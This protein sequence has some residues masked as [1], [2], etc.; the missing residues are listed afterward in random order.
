MESYK[1]VICIPQKDLY[2]NNRFLLI[3]KTIANEQNL[4]SSDGIRFSSSYQ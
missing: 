1:L 4:N 2:F 3:K